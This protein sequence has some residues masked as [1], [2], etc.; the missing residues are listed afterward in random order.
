MSAWR[1]RLSRRS[2]AWLSGAALF[3][4]APKCLLCLAAYTGLAAAFGWK[5][6]GPERCGSVTGDAFAWWWLALIPGVLLSF[7]GLRQVARHVRR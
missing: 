6:A 7:V 3:A 1:A 4:L 5:I 2:L